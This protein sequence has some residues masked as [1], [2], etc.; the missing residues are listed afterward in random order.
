MKTL[1]T[2]ACPTLRLLV[3]NQFGINVG[4]Y[5]LMPYLASYL[6]IEI[7][8][9]AWLVGL[10]LGIRNLGQQGMFFF[11][12][13]LADRIGYRP[14]I[15]A[16]CLLRTAAFGLLAFA[17]EPAV[18]I[19]AAFATG[20][21]GALFNPA[22]RAY[23]AA[24]SGEHT[25]ES[26]ALFNIGYQAG[27]LAGPV[28]GLALVAWDFRFAA[29]GA[30]AVF[31]VLT[32]LQWR[33]L[34]ERRPSIDRRQ[35]V[36]AGWRTVLTNRPF[37]WFAALMAISYVL[38]F[39]VYLAIPLALTTA[40]G[41][42]GGTLATSIAFAATGLLAVLAQAPIQ[43]WCARLPASA[44][45]AIAVAVMAAAFLPPAVFSTGWAAGVA[46]IVCALLLTAGTLI[47][48]PY[49]MKMI[50]KLAQDRS[51][52]THYGL[53][54]TIAGLAI[55]AGTALTGRA[56]DV[57]RAL[58]VPALPWLALAVLGAVAAFSLRRMASTLD[59]RAPRPS[60]VPAGQPQ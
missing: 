42:R 52:A 56:I 32:V 58:G 39:Q 51:V 15:M 2:Q 54:Q 57:S 33:R 26:F 31:A 49:E 45:P 8:L 19:A 25:A 23:V 12:G 48:Y 1:W 20:L 4:F 7:G 27:I 53:Y 38:S 44:P 21:A 18:L 5:M 17:T 11:S 10:I 50:V 28:I 55:A 43:R 34:P 3:V 30:A 41:V 36:V 59:Q 22:V 40:W 14:L 29:T 6:S 35:T 13:T 47:G 46:A 37:R 60:P 16:G 9:T 24:E